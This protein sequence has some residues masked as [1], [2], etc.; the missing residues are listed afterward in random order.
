MKLLK[1]A[2]EIQISGLRRLMVRIGGQLKV[3]KSTWALTAPCPIAYHNLNNRAEHVLDKF[4]GR[5]VYEYKYDT[6]LAREQA[7][8][9]AQWN[10]FR[11]DFKEAVGHPQI[12]TIVIDTETDLWEM[13]RLA[14]WG[15]ESS[16][17]DQYGAVNK[18]IRNIYDAVSGTNKNLVVISEMK[19][20]YITKIV[21]T[22]TGERELSEWN[23]S[24]EFAGWGNTGYKVEVNVE[25]AF[26]TKE[27]VFSTKIVN[28]GINA[29][30]AGKVF[31]DAESN[32]PFLAAEVFPDTEPTD[33]GYDDFVAGL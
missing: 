18:D 30:L 12:R 33:W 9:Q 24:Y 26:D 17:P 31:E 13:R 2:E 22:R 10:K 19:K 25:A 16:V 27:H 14:Q 5:G 1:G 8:W 7:E 11:S 20:R 29:I 4:V 23:G 28:C 3:G 6:L 21:K 32:F 15:R